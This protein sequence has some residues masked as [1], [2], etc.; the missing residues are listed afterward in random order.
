[1]DSGPWTPFRRL[2]DGRGSSFNY[3]TAF[4]K[5]Q[6]IYGTYYNH[7]LYS[8]NLCYNV[9]TEYLQPCSGVVDCILY[10]ERSK[11]VRKEKPNEEKKLQSLLY[12]N[13]LYHLLCNKNKSKT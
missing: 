8:Y 10:A 12:E 7:S 2:I 4:L 6:P 9:I 1:M 3:L 13:T 5:S 11:V